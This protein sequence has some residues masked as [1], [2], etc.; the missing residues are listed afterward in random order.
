LNHST[1]LIYVGYFQDSLVNY[2]PGLAWK[3]DPPA[4][5]LLG[6]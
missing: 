2:L 1:S 3:L 6:S 4:L 5:C